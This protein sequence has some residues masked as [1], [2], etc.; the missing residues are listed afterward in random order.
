M[1]QLSDLLYCK[2]FSISSQRC[3]FSLYLQN[4]KYHVIQY[5]RQL[6]LVQSNDVSIIFIFNQTN[7]LLIKNKNYTDIILPDQT[8][9]SYLLYV[10][11]F[12]ILQE[13]AKRASLQRNRKDLV[14]QQIRH[15]AHYSVM[16]RV[17]FF[18]QSDQ[19]V[20]KIARDMFRM[21]MDVTISRFIQAIQDT[22]TLVDSTRQYEQTVP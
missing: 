2:I 15:L 3:P 11:I 6:R 21:G 18:S 20:S 8:Q 9:L 17:H 16:I 4:R 1:R 22:T 14:V 13:D 5:I 10:T 19:Y 12:S 7:N